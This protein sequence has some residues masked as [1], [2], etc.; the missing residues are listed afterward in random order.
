MTRDLLHSLRWLR[1]HPLFAIS[2][3][4]I[5]A[6]GVGANAAVFSVVDA[7]LLHP[8][9]YESSPGLVRIVGA[10][11]KRPNIALSAADYL[12][13][14]DQ[15][16]P[17]RRDL[18]TVAVPLIRDYGV[19]LTGAGEPDQFTALRTSG[20]LFPMLGVRARLGRA[21]TQA[22][23][24]PD[25]PNL[26]V[27]SDRLWQR[28]FHSDPTVIGR[29][30][31][32]SGELFTV[33][34]VMPPAFDFP[35]PEIEMWLNVHLTPT[36]P[37]PAQVAARLA[38]GITAS[39][40][41]A[42]LE[43]VAHRLEQQH[44]ERDAGL[45]LDVS[46]WS[47][48]IPRESRLTL[49]FI[50]AAVGLVLLIACADA[51]GLLLSRAVERQKEIAVRASLG[52]GLWQ[53]VRQLLAEGLT[54]AV[55]GSLAG[56]AVARAVLQVLTKQLAGLPVSLPHLQRISLNGRVL[57]FSAALC[58]ALAVLCSLAPVLFARKIDLQ[59]VLRAG[60]GTRQHGSSRLF[61][62]LIAAET[63]FAFLLLAGS[64]LMLHSLIRLQQADRGF[65]PDHVL[66][67]R[68]P[69]GGGT[70]YQTKGK[71]DTKPRQMAYYR[72]ILERIER[73]PG[74]TAAAFVNNLPLSGAVTSLSFE[75]GGPLLN[76]RTISA[77][78][79]T[80]MGIPL[81]EGRFFT[82]AEENK[83]PGV[84]INQSMARQ[85]FPD[86]DPLG[87][88]LSG[89]NGPGSGPQVIGVV[90]DSSL[91]NYDSPAGPEE[92][93][94]YQQVLFGTFLSTFVVRTTGDPVKLADTLR[95][96]VWAVDPDQPIV[97]VETMDDI[98]ADSIWRPRFST[99]VFSVLGGLALVLACTGIYS[100]IA[101]TATLRAREVGIR[102]ALGATPS[103]VVSLILRDAML[104]VA[105]GLAASLFAALLLARLLNGL[106]YDTG[107]RDPVA[108]LGAA[109]VLL[110]VGAAASLRPAMT[111][112]RADPV[113]SL[114]L[115]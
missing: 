80:A 84:V 20:A 31:T 3:T 50:L 89:A 87:Q 107:P 26:A 41:Q 113:R 62:T 58:L 57:L 110:L 63:G 82:D 59:S 39:Q 77:H 43:P 32:V 5:L 34:G 68:V 92:Y 65:H 9:P 14:F 45:R 60:H 35:S 36:S 72:D 71:Y 101:Y 73:I 115:E 74:V 99:W 6:L 17:D 79:F 53:V 24:R 10:S 11:A 13:I 106:L 49:I 4:A 15:Q 7:V 67:L 111:A 54:L 81:I 88:H 18:F 30:I 86:R 100:V 33:A 1:T 37:G 61:S 105:L 21:L 78:Y 19:T 93:V 27:L 91:S 112:A 97:K 75:K 2:V 42:A 56:I 66:T 44:G 90:K 85:Q 28:H 64:G 76:A 108:Y 25:A 52:A 104:P 70:S 55:L 29:S 95:K 94:S 48:V 23:D 40:A 16:R 46:P 22:D 8:L 114:R 109:A 38:P 103:N 96:E 98:V 51:G 102:V 83:P 12:T 69:L 47:D